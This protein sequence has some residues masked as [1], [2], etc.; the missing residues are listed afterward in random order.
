MLGP[1]G[2]G[3]SSVMMAGLL[4]RLREKHPDWLYLDP[5]VPGSQPLENLS[6]VLADVL[7]YIPRDIRRELDNPNTRGLHVLAKQASKG[8]RLVLYIDQF[9][10]VFTQVSDEAERRQFIDLL[11]TAASEP[12]GVLYLLLSMR[13]DFYDRPLQFTPFGK[14]IETHHAAITPMMLADLYDVVQKPAALPDVR[15]TFDDGLVTEMIFDV[16]AEAAAPEP[17]L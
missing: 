6:I 3:K 9:E 8:T 15:L 1:S 2:S 12:D 13:A 11:G 14:L 10:E 5:M 4:P 7:S 16:R 17:L